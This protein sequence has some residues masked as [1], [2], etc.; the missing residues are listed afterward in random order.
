MNKEQLN[1][2]WPRV[3]GVL[4]V[5]ITLGVMF[6]WNSTGITLAVLFLA[7]LAVLMFHEFE[8]Y[9]F[10]G[11]FK[12]FMNHHT[13]FA[14]PEPQNNAPASE[15]L[16][17]YVNLGLWPVYL[18]GYLLADSIPWLGVGMVIFNIANI[19]GHVI[20]FQIKKKGYNPGFITALF[21]M[22]PIT[23]FML[24][25]IN[26]NDVLTAFEYILSVFVG[27]VTAAALPVTGVTL[28][29]KALAALT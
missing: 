21:L 8:E 26:T 14:L 10:P 5:L 18:I 6:E 16:I 11:G 13:V 7:N 2:I 19:F 27:L 12:H 17:L 1:F 29:K 23:A 9:V 4:A 22:L 24:Y 15:G 25:F 28:R 3:G 20:L